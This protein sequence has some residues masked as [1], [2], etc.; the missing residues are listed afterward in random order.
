MTYVRQ[1]ISDTEGMAMI[2]P[3]L[4]ITGLTALIV[5]GGFALVAYLERISGGGYGHDAGTE[6]PPQETSSPVTPASAE[7]ASDTPER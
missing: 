3:T 4:I 6:P 2:L 5:W 1:G 7:S